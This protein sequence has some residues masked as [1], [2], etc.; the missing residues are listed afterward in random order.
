[1][2]FFPSRQ[3]FLQVGPLAIHWYGLMYLLAFL[4]I[5]W[6]VPRLQKY[7]GLS[8]SGE[9]ISS[10]L[11]YGI[12]GTLIGGRLGYIVF[13]APEYFGENPWQILAVWNGGMAS[14]GGF[15][16]VAV[17]VWLFCRKHS[18]N[19]WKLADVLVIPIALG[20][21]L[22][23]VGNFINLELFGPVT[24][25]P[26][27]IEIPGE[28]GLR[29]PTPLY[30]V[31]KNILIAGVCYLSLRKV[32]KPGSTLG[33]FLVLYAILRFLIEY[34]RVETAQGFDLGILYLT[35]GQLLTLPV[36]A[37]GIWVLCCAHRSG[38]SSVLGPKRRG[39]TDTPQKTHDRPDDRGSTESGG[40]FGS[41][42][43]SGGGSDLGHSGL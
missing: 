6:S 13:Y 3:I 8:F 15:I 37:L 34:L 22:G 14:H 12:L 28:F 35:R 33:I 21:A 2:Q 25:L 30:A 26:W 7:R 43:D 31:A 17:A 27:A 19:F 40:T 41:S 23:R 9:Q 36:F 32:E 10:L 42:S 1:M 4:V 38:N 18:V 24:T 5:W 11:T 20:L 16:G 29:H 39:S